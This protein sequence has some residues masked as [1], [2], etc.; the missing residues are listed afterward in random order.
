MI[1]LISL[2]GHNL[3]Q[4]MASI[5]GT[6]PNSFHHG[7]SLPSCPPLELLIPASAMI[8]LQRCSHFPWQFSAIFYLW[9]CQQL[10]PSFW[11]HGNSLSFHGTQRLNSRTEGSGGMYASPRSAMRVALTV[12]PNRKEATDQL[13]FWSE[14]LD[15]FLE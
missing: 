15:Q 6:A 10:G 3:T 11:G 13:Q 8:S 12:G 7:R 1:A 2:H 4:L 9:H 5:P 14:S